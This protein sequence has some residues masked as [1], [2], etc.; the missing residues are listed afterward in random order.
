[1]LRL[2]LLLVIFLL[3]LLV[4]FRAP[5]NSLWYVSIVVTELSILLFIATLLLLIWQQHS[6]KY[7]VAATLIGV[8]ALIILAL[9]IVGAYRVSNHL[10]NRFG[11]NQAS[12]P[13]SFWRMITGINARRVSHTTFTYDSENHL[14]LDYYRSEVKG[15]RPCVVVVHGGSWASGESQQ[16][17]ELNSVLAKA[18]YHVTA[19]NYRLVPAAKFPAPIE[20]VKHALAYLRQQSARLSIDTNNFVLL[21]R[22]AG[23]QIVLIAAYTLHDPSI[24]GVINFY[25]PA[26]MVW[27]YANPT[28]K[29]VMDSRKVMAGYLGGTY[30]EVPHQYVNSSAT[31]TVSRSAPPTLQLYGEHDPLV[32]HLHGVRLNKKLDSLG[33]Q[34]YDVVLPWATHAFDATLNGP[35]GQLSTW[36]VLQF[37]QIVFAKA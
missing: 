13:F 21:G 10:K 31:E 32:S 2:I 28:N 6:G 8:A 4:L 36:S 37:L 12:Q 33:N 15:K 14:A 5:T 34:H 16:L 27:G 18:G 24:K 26:D 20:D 29:L 22:S 30:N 3:S 17:P 25:G 7:N 1:M 23:G 11:A 35:G 9:P 19:I